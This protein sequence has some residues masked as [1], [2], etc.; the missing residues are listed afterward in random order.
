MGTCSSSTHLHTYC[1]VS[2]SQLKHQILGVGGYTKGVLEWF[3]YPHAS[4]NPGCKVSCQHTESTCIA[5]CLCFV[6]TSPM[7]EKATYIVLESG[8]TRSLIAKLLQRSSL[9]VCKFPAASKERC[10]KAM[11]RCLQNFDAGCH[12]T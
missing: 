11:D 6:K 1:I 7:V 10:K 5:L 12:S 8:P 4:A 9:A 3:N 2:G